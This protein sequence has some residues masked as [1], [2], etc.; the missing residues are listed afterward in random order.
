MT[1]NMFLTHLWLGGLLGLIGQSI[2]VIVGLK[3][4]Y[5]YSQQ[6]NRSFAQVFESRQL[7]TSLLIGFIAGCL[8][9][10]TMMNFEAVPPKPPV[11][12]TKELIVELIAIGYAGT[13]F[14]EAFVKK[15]IPSPEEKV[16]RTPRGDA[17]KNAAPVNRAQQTTTPERGP[18]DHP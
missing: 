10:I 5:D 8:G 2:R 7:F 18:I 15:Y 9:L 1:I 6:T 3:K 16:Q 12:L 11:T 14:I 17:Y 4:T 13:D